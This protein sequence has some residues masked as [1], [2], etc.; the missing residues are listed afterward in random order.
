[1]NSYTHHP[2]WENAAIMDY[3]GHREEISLDSEKT[4]IVKFFNS[5]NLLDT[6]IQIRRKLKPLIRRWRNRNLPNLLKTTL[7]TGLLEAVPT[8]RNDQMEKWKNGK[9]VKW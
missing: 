1:M 3:L 2:W 4:I 9:M 5:I 6:A 8:E 7:H